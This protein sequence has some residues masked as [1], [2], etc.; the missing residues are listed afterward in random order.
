MKRFG[1]V[2][3]VLP[4][5]IDEYKRLHAAVWPGVLKRI[6]ESAIRKEALRLKIPCLTNLS[7]A[8][9]ACEAVETLRGEMKVRAIQTLK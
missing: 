5:K 1:M 9:A 8:L 7:A 2:A 6:D 4:G 3:R